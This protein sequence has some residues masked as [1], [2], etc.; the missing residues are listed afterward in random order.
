MSYQVL[1]RKWR[2][3]TFNEVVGQRHVTESLQNSIVNNRLGHAYVLTGTRGIGKT[4]VARI[5]AKSVRCLERKSDGN[6]CE[7]CR[8]CLEFDE[9]SSMNIL[10]MDGAS[11]NSVDDIRDLV[12]NIQTL[13]TYGEYKVY[14]IDEVHM[15]SV[16]AFNALLK[17]L[18]EPP[19]HVIFLMATTEPHKIPDT[20]LS[21]CQRF[22]FRNASVELIE[23]HLKEISEKENIIFE[24]SMIP[25]LIASQA[26]GSFRD[27]L[28]LLDQVL[29]F[30]DNS[31]ISEESVSLALG[32]AKLS[33]VRS[34]AYYILIEDVDS[35]SE[36]YRELLFS[37]VK[38]E[39][40]TKALL[41]TFYDVIKNVDM[42]DSV[43]FTV[44]EQTSLSEITIDELYWIYEGLCKDFSWVVDSV[45]PEKSLEIV[46]QKYALRSQLLA[47]Q[48]S[49]IEKKKTKKI[50][51]VKTWE[52]FEKLVETETPAIA[53][54]LFHGNILKE[55]VITS[56]NISVS[57][58]FSENSYL[59]FDHLSQE[60]AK[61]KLELMMCS[62]FKKEKATVE[63]IKVKS[64]REDFQSKAEIIEEKIQ[65]QNDEKLHNF[66]NHPIVK[67]AEKIFNSTLDKVNIKE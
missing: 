67:E 45:S 64:E 12:G 47:R 55:P 16:S 22:D 5:F 20:V 1:S 17:T 44:D 30:S 57:Y 25:A 14:I 37:N 19:E 21:R 27:S 28:S 66:K 39:N 13:P 29:S 24:S 33:T 34:L 62:F 46:L 35:I 2:P 49:Q 7:K 63:F 58:G 53:A 23:K 48:S 3:K 43:G 54:Q 11:N 26:Q 6:P 38:L 40:I 50:I 42:L 4:S 60:G 18:E 41:D 59:F 56:D 31:S 15:L 8:S 32:L 65:N 61:E 52:G 9:S 10:E 51:E 36:L